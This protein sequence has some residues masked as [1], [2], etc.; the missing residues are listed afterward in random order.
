[1]DFLITKGC[2]TF[3]GYFFSRPLNAEAFADYIGEQ[4]KSYI[5]NQALHGSDTF[6]TT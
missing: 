4:K 6:D 2:N 5:V 3:Q 1:M